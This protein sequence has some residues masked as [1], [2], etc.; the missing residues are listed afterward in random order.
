MEPRGSVMSGDI[1]G[2]SRT[3]RLL[4]NLQVLY[5]SAPR[6]IAS[7]HEPSLPPNVWNPLSGREVCGN[8]NQVLKMG[9]SD[10]DTTVRRDETRQKNKC[11]Q[12]APCL[13]AQISKP[14]LLPCAPLSVRVRILRKLV[15]TPVETVHPMWG[16]QVKKHAEQLGNKV[17]CSL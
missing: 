12:Q 10:P 1:W 9:R 2:P 13:G 6:R 11:E 4:G 14:K 7:H 3:G 17:G 15:R 5:L 8:E 16:T